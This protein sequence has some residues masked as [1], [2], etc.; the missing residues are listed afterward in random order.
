MEE[1]KYLDFGF[2]VW[3]KPALDQ[4]GL[5]HKKKKASQSFREAFGVEPPWIKR[6]AT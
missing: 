1:G 3:L 4:K 6:I 5:R 2:L